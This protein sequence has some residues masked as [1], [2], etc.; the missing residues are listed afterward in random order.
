MR[1]SVNHGKLRLGKMA[2]W[3]KWSTYLLLSACLLSGLIWFVLA[4]FFFFMPTSL[5]PWWVAHGSSS[6]LCLLILGAAV[7]HHILVTWR[8]HRNRLGGLAASLVLLGLVMTALLLFYGTEPFHDAVR[9]I[10][11]VLGLGIL[12][13][14]PWHIL[15]GK[16]SAAQIH[17]TRTA[18]AVSQ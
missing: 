7:P 1:H 3:Q 10:H 5:K 8:S 2:P 14:F 6:L 18:V 9:W 17:Q 16:K 11:I 13:L 15:R 12:I 4:D